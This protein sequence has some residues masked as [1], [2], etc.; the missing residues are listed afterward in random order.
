MPLN[1]LVC[2]VAVIAIVCAG[3]D[4]GTGPCIALREPQCVGHFG[5]GPK[6]DL[7]RCLPTERWMWHLRVVLVD[8][9]FDHCTNTRHR[10]QGVQIRRAH[11]LL[12]VL[13]QTHAR[14]LRQE[15][16]RCR[17]GGA[18]SRY[19][20]LCTADSLKDTE[21]SRDTSG[22]GPTAPNNRGCRPSMD[23]ARTRGVPKVI[24]NPQAASRW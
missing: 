9:E 8:V 5:A 3:W 6:E 4:Q 1:L 16:Q 14:R 18:R 2:A 22:I 23:R 10:I 15:R 12:H 24:A 11:P 17:S 21:S 20:S 7:V 13:G 19:L